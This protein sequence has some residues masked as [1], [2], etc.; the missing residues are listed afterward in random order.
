MTQGGADIIIIEIKYTIKVIHLNHLETIP[1]P[2]SMGTWSSRK[3]VSGAKKVED[4]C[5]TGMIYSSMYPYGFSIHQSMTLMF[6]ILIPIGIP[7]CLHTDHI[8]FFFLLNSTL[9]S[10]LC[11]VT[12]AV[13]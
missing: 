1:T 5:L 11:T 2:W 12:K 7:S 10:C 13:G 3:P 6:Q 4:H 9:N 8:S